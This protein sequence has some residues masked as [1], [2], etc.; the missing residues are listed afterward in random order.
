MA[1]Q[2][3]AQSPQP[4]DEG[5]RKLLKLAVAAGSAAAAAAVLPGSWSKPIA[6]I[7]ALP[8]HAQTSDVQIDIAARGGPGPDI[9]AFPAPPPDARTQGDS[10]SWMI[11]AKCLYNDTLAELS[12]ETMI[13]TVVDGVCIQD[14]KGKYYPYFYLSPSNSEGTEGTLTFN[15]LTPCSSADTLEWYLHMENGRR[16]NSLS[17]PI[18]KD[19]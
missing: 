7:G 6:H 13:Y 4:S 8:A 15:V 5:R 9:V 17:G 16:S 18:V 10:A 14:R 1:E 11:Q 12:D 3:V 2:Q 19:I